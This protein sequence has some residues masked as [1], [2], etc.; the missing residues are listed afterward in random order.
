[1]SGTLLCASGTCDNGC[2]KKHYDWGLLVLRIGMGIIF[3]FMGYGKLFGGSPGIEGF[4]SMLT[5]IGIPA[6]VF[7]AYLVGII[8]FFG[9]IAIILG[10]F[11]RVVAPLLAIIMVVAFVAVKKVLPG[12]NIDLALFAISVA[13]TLTGPGSYSLLRKNSN[14]NVSSKAQS[15]SSGSAQ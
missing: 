3:I 13:L 12:G 10:M 14:D 2:C 8:E 5:N 15:D 9:G 1:M 11:T 4:T 7:S 6:P